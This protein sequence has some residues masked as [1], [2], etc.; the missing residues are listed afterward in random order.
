MS[1]CGK[2]KIKKTGSSAEPKTNVY[3]WYD[4]VRTSGSINVN[5]PKLH[6]YCKIHNIDKNNIPSYVLDMF[7]VRTII[8]NRAKCRLCRDILESITPTECI[9]CR[10]GEITIAG[11]KEFIH[12]CWTT[13]RNNIIEM[14]E[15]AD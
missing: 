10:C 13:D 3:P 12:R 9:T 5:L 7:R 1:D 11:G 8:R 2:E 6:K 14:I 4:P 15:Y